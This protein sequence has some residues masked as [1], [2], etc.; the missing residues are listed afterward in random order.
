[1]SANKNIDEDG[2]HHDPLNQ[3]TYEAVSNSSHSAALPEPNPGHLTT[4][5]ETLPWYNL[6]QAFEEMGGF[7]RF[8]WFSTF[9]LTI[10]RNAGNYMYYGFAYLTMEQMY[11]C[12]FDPSQ[13]FESCS[14][15]EVICPALSRGDENL[16]YEVDQSYEYYLNN[17]YVQM[18]LVCANKIRTNSM[19]SFKYIA[20]GIAGLLLFAMPDR[21]GRK[22][23][24]VVNFAVHL[25]AQYLILFD[26]DYWAR[27]FA[28][29]LYGCAQLKQTVV[30]V[31]AS[32]L[33]PAANSTNVTVSLSCF[34][35][36]SLAFICTYFLFIS[37]DWFPLMLFMTMLST[38]SFLV[39]VFL[40]PESPSWLFT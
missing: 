7:G 17:W 40:L 25:A 22:F 28:L 10:A 23:S 1:M 12:R 35:S 9:F 36:G 27:S 26:S 3:S 21:Y 19:I 33:A 34:D 32:E 6:E 16:Q 15:E 29:I 11:L 30:Y 4:I 31:W 18:D 20:F 5:E 24:M 14:A 8:Q 38:L 2:D 39:C 13:P 37:R